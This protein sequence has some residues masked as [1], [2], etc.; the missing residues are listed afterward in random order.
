MKI[1][2]DGTA[3]NYNAGSPAGNPNK[4]DLEAT[5]TTTTTMTTTTTTTT[6]RAPSDGNSGNEGGKTCFI[7]SPF[8]PFTF[9]P[10][11]EVNSFTG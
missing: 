10:F 3:S 4:I 8:S 9:L 11:Y 1:V 2:L 7:I 5:T 6:T